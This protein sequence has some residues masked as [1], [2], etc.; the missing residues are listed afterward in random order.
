MSFQTSIQR[1]FST[2]MFFSILKRENRITWENK[3]K[4]LSN[5]TK[6]N[7]FLHLWMRM[8]QVFSRCIYR[9]W[10]SDIESK[11]K[12]RSGKSFTCFLRCG[13][14][15]FVKYK[16]KDHVPLARQLSF[17]KN[18][19]TRNLF[20]GCHADLSFWEAFVASKVF[21]IFWCRCGKVL[22]ENVFFEK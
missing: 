11:I 18:I 17:M 12:L 10:K 9:I 13:A 2:C 19:N 16:R 14:R 5:S 22:W 3:K 8:Q 20:D 4:M 1:D 7:S 6:I 21:D 15:P